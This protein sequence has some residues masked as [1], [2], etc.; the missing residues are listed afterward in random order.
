[1]WLHPIS[2]DLL[3]TKNDSADP[4][5]GE[6]VKISHPITDLESLNS[7]N[8]DFVILGYADDEG[9]ALNGGR[10]GAQSAPKMI[11]TSL[12]KMTPR[13]ESQN[14][15][16]ILDIGDIGV[17]VD[18]N[19]RHE[20]ARKIISHI[21]N[22]SARF[23]SFGGGHDYGYSD[24]CG[25]LDSNKNSVVINFDAHLDV[26]PNIVNNNS[27]TPFYRMLNEH[28]KNVFFMEVGI[29]E[30]C[31]SLTH[32]DWA[33]AQGAIILKQEYPT[34][35]LLTQLKSNLS[36]H[37]GKKLFISL[38]MDVFNSQEAPGC[39][40][41]WATGISIQQFMP[42]LNWLN[43]NFDTRGLGIYEVSPPLDFDNKTSKLA[44]L[45]AHRFIFNHIAT[46]H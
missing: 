4:R 31:N 8:N 28:S 12:Y 35:D 40:Q 39:S 34:S 37:L 17:E 24:S 36:A 45:I 5:M 29:Q 42:I 23:V 22:T 11:R 1:M 18:L 41:S 44:A 43:E 15:P 32:Y 26:R 46:G 38:D 7:A 3:F 9:I 19:T 33:K 16:K 14:A 25:F 6:F 2:K 30:Q 13:L 27:G 21:S 10:V 20:R